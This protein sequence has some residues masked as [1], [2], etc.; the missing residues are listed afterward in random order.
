[1]V[2][3]TVYC[4]G[5]ECKC[6][7]LMSLLRRC[8]VTM[9]HSMIIVNAPLLFD[10]QQSGERMVDYAQFIYNKS[11]NSPKIEGSS[12]SE[13]TPLGTPT[14]NTTETVSKSKSNDKSSLHGVSPSQASTQV[15][16]AATNCL[17]PQKPV[18]LLPEVPSL[19]SGRKLSE[20]EQRDCDIIGMPLFIPHM[21]II[22]L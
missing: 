14:H 21:A 10:Q 2:Y 9:P 3:P 15:A 11:R 8:F 6:F 4:E 19:A 20:K 22:F 13:C 5:G 17:S 18:N 12:S 1:M 16:V 7:P